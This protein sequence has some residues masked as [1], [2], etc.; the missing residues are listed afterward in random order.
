MTVDPEP[1]DPWSAHLSR[2][3][4]AKAQLTATPLPPSNEELTVLVGLSLVVEEG[5]YE[6]LREHAAGAP[7]PST[8]EYGCYVSEEGAAAPDSW[9]GTDAHVVITGTHEN[10]WAVTVAGAGAIG[11]DRSGRLEISFER[12]PRMAVISP[13]GLV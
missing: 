9:A 11:R 7:A 2:F 10:G 8:L 12:P 1:V 4:I 6:N 3:R 13:E 5:R